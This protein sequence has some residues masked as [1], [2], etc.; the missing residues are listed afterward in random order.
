[1]QAV[2][3]ASAA[4]SS[5]ASA[6]STTTAMC[7]DVV[8]RARKIRDVQAWPRSPGLG[9]APL[10]PRHQR[11][12]LLLRGDKLSEIAPARHDL[13][14]AQRAQRIERGALLGKP[15]LPNAFGRHRES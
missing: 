4:V 13:R 6:T 7:V 10:L 12:A 5:A 15:A 11:N 8:A 3:S 2:G 9:V 14:Q 1:M